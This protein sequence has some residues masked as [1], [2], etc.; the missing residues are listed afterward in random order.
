MRLIRLFFQF[1][2]SWGRCFWHIELGNRRNGKDRTRKDGK[3]NPHDRPTDVPNHEN[4][5]TDAPNRENRPTD[6]PDP[7]NRPK[8]NDGNDG[9]KTQSDPHFLKNKN[10]RLIRLFFQFFTS[11]GRCFSFLSLF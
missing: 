5:P 2:T 1:F 4:K 6:A 8:M 10:M 9:E 3:T 11:W 7:D